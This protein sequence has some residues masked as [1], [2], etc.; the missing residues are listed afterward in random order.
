M[1]RVLHRKRKSLRGLSTHT[2]YGTDYRPYVCLERFTIRVLV[3]RNQEFWM[4]E[5]MCRGSMLDGDVST[6][7]WTT[8]RDANPG[9]ILVAY[10]A[11][12]YR[13]TAWNGRECTLLYACQWMLTGVSCE[14]LFDAE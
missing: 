2:W 6:D 11:T 5:R 7:E 8:R 12:D 10:Q 3:R 4:Y 1:A 9:A 14:L 13:M